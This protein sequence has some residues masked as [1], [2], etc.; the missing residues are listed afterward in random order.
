MM[1]LLSKLFTKAEDR[2]IGLKSSLSKELRFEVFTRDDFSLIRIP[3]RNEY[4]EA[5]FRVAENL[6]AELQ[7]PPMYYCPTQ[8]RETGKL[9]AEYPSPEII[10]RELLLHKDKIRLQIDRDGGLR[11]MEKTMSAFISQ[12]LYFAMCTKLESFLVISLINDEVRL[13][14]VR[15]SGPISQI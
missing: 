8:C 12:P 15:N 14:D 6:I 9:K 1:K 11:E 7:L 3:G 10:I 5:Q 4:E 2:P 13:I